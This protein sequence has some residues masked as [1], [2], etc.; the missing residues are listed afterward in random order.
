[1]V[2]V[3]VRSVEINSMFQVVN[4]GPVVMTQV[5][6]MFDFID[7]GKLDQFGRS[8]F[9]NDVCQLIVDKND[10]C[11]IQSLKEIGP[12]VNHFDNHVRNIYELHD[13]EIPLFSLYHLIKHGK[14]NYGFSDEEYQEYKQKALK[15]CVDYYKIKP[16]SL[17]EWEK[18][19]L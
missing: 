16:S 18:N 11:I 12:I 2:I 7:R 10:R 15:A 3:L 14:D 4:V 17:L 13:S 9:A 19:N 1:V 8:H 5:I 6:D